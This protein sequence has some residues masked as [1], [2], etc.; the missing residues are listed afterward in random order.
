MRKEFESVNEFRQALNDNLKRSLPEPR[1]SK[2]ISRARKNGFIVQ[3]D[4]Q[5]GR[6]I[7]RL[8]GISRLFDRSG[9]YRHCNYRGA[10]KKLNVCALH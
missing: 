7:N 10:G 8:Y 3:A 9:W 1:Y 2:A 6:A 5:I 4:G